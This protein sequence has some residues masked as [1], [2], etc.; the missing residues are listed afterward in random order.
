[1]SAAMGRA[2]LGTDSVTPPPKD[3]LQILQGGPSATWP[4]HSSREQEVRVKKRQVRDSSDNNCNKSC[5]LK[6]LS[7]T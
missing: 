4:H 3:I 6:L 7:N 2:E 5:L 1:M